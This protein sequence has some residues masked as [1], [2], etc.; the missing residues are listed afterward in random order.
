MTNALF[1]RTTTPPA[2]FVGVDMAKHSFEWALHGVPG[3]HSASNDEAGFQAL[4]DALKDRS[5]SLLV[6]EATGG[7][8][9]ALARFVMHR[10]VR[11]HVANPRL[12]REFARSMGHLAKTDAIDATALA[13]YAHTLAGK[14]DQ[15]GLLFAPP[16][17]E[18]EALQ[19]MLT[20]RVQLIDMRTAEKNRLG[21]PVRV[22]RKSVLA[23]IEALDKQIAI[24]DKDI[25]AHLKQH[26]EEQAKRL[27]AIKG[28]GPIVCATLL[29]FMHE[30]GT[31]TPRSAA[32]LAGVAP[33]NNDSGRSHGKQH[34]W[35]GRAIVRS[36]LHMA[37][38][39]AVRFNPVLK[40]FYDRL[41][42][43]GKPR[44]VALTACSHKLLRIVN[45]MAR[46]G[47]PWNDEFHAVT[48]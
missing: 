14:A 45:A 10:G 22:M 39:S 32:M 29:A 40:T 25:N 35:G 34:V 23:I 37:M 18:L 9:M 15:A 42:A 11:V 1:E 27:E 38:L 6:V 46:T 3:S 16:G 30:L 8:E 17:P 12:A 19:A 13:H 24:L 5:I 41:I 4:L 36:T 43:N 28:V 33:L 26:F 7:L 20:R 48:P 47:Q 2:T 21:G 31:I 44:K